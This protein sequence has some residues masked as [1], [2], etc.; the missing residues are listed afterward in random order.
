MV[1]DL[2]CR[3]RKVLVASQEI[4]LYEI[5]EHGVLVFRKAADLEARRIL[6][7]CELAVQEQIVP[8]PQRLSREQW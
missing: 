5:D 8:A 6:M 2:Q 3:G 1:L 7:L 4:A